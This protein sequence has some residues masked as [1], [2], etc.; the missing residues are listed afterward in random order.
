MNRLQLAE[1]LC[2]AHRDEMTRVELENPNVAIRAKIECFNGS[3]VTFRVISSSSKIKTSKM[4]EMKI[5]AKTKKGQMEGRVIESFDSNLIINFKGKWK[6]SSN[7]EYLLNTNSNFNNEVLLNEAEKFFSSE[8]TI[9][10]D[11]YNFYKN[12]N[13]ENDKSDLKDLAICDFYNKRLNESQKTC[14]IKSI[15]D[16]PFKI[17][18]P[19]GTGKTET[20]VE[21]ILQNLKIKKTVIVCGPSNISIDN[22]ITRYL[23]SEFDLKE[24]TSFYRLGS[25]VKG[26]THFNIES[27]AQDSVK[28]MEKEEDDPRFGK[29]VFERKQNF[30]TTFRKASPLAFSTLFSSLKESFYFDLCIVDEACQ[31]SQ[32]ECFMGIVKAKN[33]ILVGDPNQLCPA[34]CSLY[35]NL[36]IPTIIL[37]EQY[38]MPKDLMEFSN[39]YFYSNQIISKND[40]FFNIFNQS[41]ILFIDTSYFSFKEE[42]SEL[43]KI[44]NNE[45]LLVQRCVDWLKKKDNLNIGVIAPYSAQVQLLRTLVDVQVET[46][47]GFQG[48]ERDFIILSLVRSNDESE[49]GFLNDKKRLNVAITRCRKGLIVIGDA[50]NFR[51]NRF[52]SEFFKFLNQSAE[53]VDP[54]TFNLLI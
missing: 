38:R 18:G 7:S 52:Y 11:I 2:N 45:A 37:N 34:S 5:F 47:D 28:F 41:K 3:L 33:F 17:L 16:I 36:Y 15:D 44:N 24:N 20:I 53:V 25:S 14:V 22:V 21:I 31:A 39:N 51:K 46:V 32:L 1:T 8:K 42:L 29:E 4:I 27:M 35:E 13:H 40:K 49:I 12:P 50:E 6:D 9:H 10:S 43:S 23:G 26:L 48:Q 30:M 54:E 19:P